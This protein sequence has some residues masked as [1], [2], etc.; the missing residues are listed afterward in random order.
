MGFNSA[1][2]GLRRYTFRIKLHT[3]H[4]NV[5]EGCNPQES[6]KNVLTIRTVTQ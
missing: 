4:R 6:L 2:K 5:P 1:F 3:A